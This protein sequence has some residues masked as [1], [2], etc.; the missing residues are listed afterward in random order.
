[1]FRT[2]LASLVFTIPGVIAQDCSSAVITY[3]GSLTPPGVWDTGE[4][5]MLKSDFSV[6]PDSCGDLHL[7]SCLAASVVTE[8]TCLGP[9]A[10]GL[11]YGRIQYTKS[12]PDLWINA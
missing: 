4:I 2:L 11:D 5:R 3:S 10:D 7:D 1:M 9:S 8:V 12:C 6:V